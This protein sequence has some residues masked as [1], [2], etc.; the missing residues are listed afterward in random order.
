MS[1]HQAGYYYM[2]AE[3]RV[4]GAVS[5]RLDIVLRQR[6]FGGMQHCV[7]GPSNSIGVEFVLEAQPSSPPAILSATPFR[8][9]NALIP[10]WASR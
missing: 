8:N 4:Q 10:S 2:P 5:A 9:H 3:Q 6:R 7:I 1:F